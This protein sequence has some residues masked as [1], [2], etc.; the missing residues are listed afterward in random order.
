VQRI[1]IRLHS[2]RELLNRWREFHSRAVFD[3][4]RSKT[5]R[6][7][8][9]QL[10][11][12]LILADSSGRGK[13]SGPALGLASTS[14]GRS[15]RGIPASDTVQKAA[16]DLSVGMLHVRSAP[17]E[18]QMHVACTTCHVTLSLPNLV[19]GSGGSLTWL[20]KLSPKVWRSHCCRRARRDVPSCVGTPDV[21]VSILQNST[22]SVLVVLAK[23]GLH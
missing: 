20:S 15:G 18:P 21:N 5:S 6:R 23:Y 16:A 8:E 10:R 4:A 3:V 19:A 17:S 11:S 22:S 13:P 9:E 2:Y 7:R 12:Q 1:V 14:L